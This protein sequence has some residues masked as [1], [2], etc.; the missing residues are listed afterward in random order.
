MAVKRLTKASQAVSFGVFQPVGHVIV[1]FDSNEEA[2]AAADALRE[3]GFDDEDILFY[4]AREES[5]E[6]GRM[7]EGIS[8]AAGFGYEVGLMRQ[9]K[10]LADQGCGW[11]LVFAPDK[12]HCERVVEIARSHGARLAEKYHSLAVEDLI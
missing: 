10:A 9:Y 12:E 8:G 3:A 4:T 7:L 2:G 5:H 11:L 1:A 6:M